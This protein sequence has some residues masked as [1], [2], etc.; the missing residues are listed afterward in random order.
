MVSFPQVSPPK[1]LYTPLLSP[2]RATCPAHLI[3][4][5]LITRTI[6]GE[7][8]RSLSSS[9]CSFLHSPV[10]SSLSGSNILNTLFLSPSAYIPPS[11]W[12]AKFHTHT[13]EQQPFNDAGFKFKILAK[14]EVFISIIPSTIKFCGDLI[15]TVQE[16][17]S[18]SDANVKKKGEGFQRR[19]CRCLFWLLEISSFG[20]EQATRP[21][22]RNYWGRNAF[23]Q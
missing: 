9:L 19:H 13:Q 14:T 12:V 5:G 7:E 1:T 6:L 21:S 20:Y 8:Y 4:L 10:T 15:S 23:L 18:H 16:E 3:L 11:V 17:V 2:I 22:F